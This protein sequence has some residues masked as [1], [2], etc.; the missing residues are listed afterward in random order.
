MGPLKENQIVVRKNIKVSDINFCNTDVNSGLQY[1]I[2][3]Y[4]SGDRTDNYPWDTLLSSI[5]SGWDPTHSMGCLHTDPG[6]YSPFTVFET[7]YEGKVVFKPDNG[8]HRY[9]A[10]KILGIEEIDAFVV[11]D[12]GFSHLTKDDI[13]Q[14]VSAA[15][16][17]IGNTQQYQTLNLP[18]GVTW[19]SRDNTSDLFNFFGPPKK[20]MG[21]N[22]LDV[23]CH[24]GACALEAKRCGARRVVGFDLD[25]KLINLA[26][27]LSKLLKLDIELHH[28]DFWEFPLWEKEKFDIVMAHQCMYHFNTAHRCANSNKY[29]QEDMLNVITS[30]CKESFFSYT[31]V[32][33]DNN[34]TTEIEGYR[35]TVSQIKKDLISRHFRFVTIDTP[36]NKED[37][38]TKKFVLATR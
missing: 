30:A 5:K 2:D 11:L 7:Y 32:H 25:G 26:K 23:G 34:P 12:N 37:T 10:L 38:F 1:R 21:K 28:C 17:A 22:V 33:P 19:N 3:R 6:G 8:A 18:F 20:W 35:P 29:S 24:I 4:L 36:P 16:K 31:F 9:I 14:W 13:L 15:K 27:E